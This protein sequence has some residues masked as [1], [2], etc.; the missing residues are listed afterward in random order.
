VNLRPVWRAA[1]A[2][3]LTRRALLGLTAYAAG[4][5]TFA[6]AQA[7]ASCALT[8]DSG[9]GP[10]YLDSSL[11][12]ADIT[13]GRP[14]AP[15]ALTMR[16]VRTRDCATLGRARVDVWQADALGLYSGYARQSG[17]GGV[18]TATVAGQRYLRG[19]QFTDP[20]GEVRLRTVFPSWYGGRTPHVHFKIFIGDDAVVASQIF[21]P[22]EINDR[23]FNGWEPYRQ[24][25]AKRMTR[26][27]DDRFLRD[28]GGVLCDA[29]ESTA[30]V[31]ASALVAVNAP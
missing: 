23:V 8:P 21:F 19:T 2:D 22:D 11:V 4:G 20:D 17:V 16:I 25:V 5:L 3:R 24:H 1:S 12:R 31:R 10:F 29:E 6:R 7:P 14:G 30:G 28:G 9:E 15:L 18:S 26:N 13:D 27:A